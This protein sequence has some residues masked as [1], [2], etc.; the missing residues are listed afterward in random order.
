MHH[1]SWKFYIPSSIKAG[2][3][4]VCH[5]VL[6]MCRDLV[7]VFS[8]ASSMDEFSLNDT[9]IKSLW[10]RATSVWLSIKTKL[11]LLYHPKSPNTGRSS[12]ISIE[13]QIP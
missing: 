1:A 2:N 10:K 13:V 7:E 6:N 12:S 8:S 5:M 9:L 3:S 4:H 11:H